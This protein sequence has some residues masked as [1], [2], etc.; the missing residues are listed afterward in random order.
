MVDIINAAY[1]D[2]RTGRPPGEA[3]AVGKMVGVS[4]AALA[5]AIGHRCTSGTAPRIE[6]HIPGAN[7]TGSIAHVLSN[8]PMSRC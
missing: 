8:S 5:S 4:V 3:L 1:S 6:C 7:M 2:N